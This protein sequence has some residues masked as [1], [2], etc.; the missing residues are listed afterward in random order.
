MIAPDAVTLAASAPRGRQRSTPMRC[1]GARDRRRQ[2]R[3]DV[4]S[5]DAAA[6]PPQVARPALTREFRRRSTAAPGRR[7]DQAYIGACV[8][9]K[10]ADL[11]MAARVLRGRKVAQR[12]AP[13][14]RAGLGAQTTDAAAADGTLG[15]LDCRRAR[16]CCR[17]VAAPAPATAQACSQRAKS[18]SPRRTAISKAAWATRT[19]QVYLGSPYTVAAS[20]VAGHIADP[21]ASCKAQHERRIETVRG[22]AWVFGDNIDTDVLAPGAYMKLPLEQLGTTLPR[23]DRSGLRRHVAPGDIVVGGANFGLGSSREQAAQALKLL[24]VSAR[25]GRRASRAFS[26]ATPS[27]SACP[28]CSFRQQPRRGGTTCSRST[29]SKEQFTTHRPASCT[30]WSRCPRICCS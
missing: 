29:S 18:A 21:R 13:A 23:G 11:H 14:D 28:R 19:R 15:H 20:A 22:R 12:R 17:P 16:S 25:A 26:I 27:I 24:G 10:L 4:T 5:F 30:A 8:G 3:R 9:A 2:L 7:I 6:L 1:T